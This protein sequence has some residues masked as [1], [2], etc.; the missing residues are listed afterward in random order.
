M[1]LFIFFIFCPQQGG[2]W[3]EP[4]LEKKNKKTKK[5]K[6]SWKNIF[7]WEKGGGGRCAAM[8]N[9]STQMDHNCSRTPAQT[10]TDTTPTEGLMSLSRLEQPLGSCMSWD[11]CSQCA[12]SVRER[13]WELWSVALL[14]Y[15]VWKDGQDPLDKSWWEI[16][17]EPLAVSVHVTNSRLIFYRI[18]LQ[19]CD[20]ICFDWMAGVG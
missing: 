12:V 11:R 18:C 7:P 9:F 6:V 20:K 17:H 3:W 2:V 15:H 10:I 16:R 8:S 1:F 4:I 5:K 19:C 13:I 14:P